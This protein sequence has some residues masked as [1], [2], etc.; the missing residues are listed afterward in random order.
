MLVC[1]KRPRPDH[2]TRMAH[3]GFCRWIGFRGS[4]GQKVY[5]S[6]QQAILTLAFRP[7]DI[8]RK[9]EICDRLGVSRSPVAD[10]VARLPPM[11]WSMWCRR[12]GPSSP[13]CR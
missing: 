13:G 3:P 4:L 12:P 8:I 7:G 6:L 9:P 5:H 1:Y 11:V 10:A 2:K